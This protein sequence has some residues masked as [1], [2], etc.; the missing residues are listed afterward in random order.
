MAEEKLG[1]N[2]RRPEKRMKMTKSEIGG[3]RS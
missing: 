1:L 2:R 3:R